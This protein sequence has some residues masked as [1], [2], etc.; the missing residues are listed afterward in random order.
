MSK[1]GTIIAPGITNAVHITEF[2]LKNGIAPVIVKIVKT[3]PITI[4][5]RYIDFIFFLLLCKFQ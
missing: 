1:S 4:K 3:R 5:I 2:I